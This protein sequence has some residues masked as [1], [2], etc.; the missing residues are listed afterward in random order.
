MVQLKCECC[1]W[2]GR[3]IDSYY[4]EQVDKDLVLCSACSYALQLSVFG[5]R[6]VKDLKLPELVPLLRACTA[7]VTGAMLGETIE[8]LKKYVFQLFMVFEIRFG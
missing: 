8:E 4:D 2:D 7:Q 3:D 1:G 6:K 5:V